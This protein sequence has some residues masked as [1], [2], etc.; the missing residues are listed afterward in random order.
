MKKTKKQ[1]QVSFGDVQIKYPDA[2]LVERRIGAKGRSIA[3]QF[4]RITVDPKTIV[5][6]HDKFQPRRETA[7][8]ALAAN[9]LV[10]AFVTGGSKKFTDNIIAWLDPVNGALYV[11]SGF[12]RHIAALKMKLDEVDVDVFLGT[13]SDARI[14]AFLDNLGN[15]VEEHLKRGEIQKSIASM[16][17]S[18]GLTEDQ[19]SDLTGRP[20]SEVRKILKTV[21]KRVLS[22]DGPR[23]FFVNAKEA[24][25][26]FWTALGNE[27]G[28]SA[29]E[30]EKTLGEKYV[31]H[32]FM[33]EQSG[34]ASPF[35]DDFFEPL[36]SGFGTDD[37][38]PLTHVYVVYEGVHG[39]DTRAFDRLFRSRERLKIFLKVMKKAYDVDLKANLVLVRLNRRD[40]FDAKKLLRELQKERMERFAAGTRKR[41]WRNP[42]TIT[43]NS[44]C[45]GWRSES[46]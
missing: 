10:D 35:E 11:V 34:H 19:V 42:F 30:A 46:L 17:L 23:S 28:K 29:K 40:K 25:T 41:R 32:K 26:L 20:V 39:K 14:T 6:D 2:R 3:K 27:I 18:E 37:R 12:K 31:F 44:P 21:E 5:S 22:E 15:Q 16:V 24:E 43:S 4:A 9:K 1:V 45:G 38:P 7:N 36:M 8:R 33:T 13:E